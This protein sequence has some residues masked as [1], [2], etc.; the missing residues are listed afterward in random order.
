MTYRSMQPSDLPSLLRLERSYMDTVEPESVD[1]WTAALDRNLQLWVDCLPTSGVIT[2][3]EDRVAGIALWQVHA[4]VATLVTIHVTPRH[5]R[6]GLGGRLLEAF[7][8]AGTAAGARRAVLGVHEGNT[9][10]EELYEKHGFRFVRVDGPY[11]LFERV[12]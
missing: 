5:R 12:S 11:R 7:V 2:D 8:A 1:A 9:G 10:A 6:A 3:D 4:D